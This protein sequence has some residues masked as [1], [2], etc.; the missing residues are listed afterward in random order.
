[1]ASGLGIDS[2][3]GWLMTKNPDLMAK[4]DILK[5]GVKLLI[6][7]SIVA[8]LIVIFVS[9]VFPNWFKI[10][11]KMQEFNYNTAKLSFIIFILGAI[12]HLPLNA[13]SNSLASFGKAY[14]GTLISTIQVFLNFL[15]LIITIKAKF[16][17]PMY[18]FLYSCNTVFCS[19]IK[20]IVVLHSIKKINHLSVEIT[21]NKKN[22]DNRYI[23]IL[24]MGIN[25]SL[26]GV[27]LMLV[28]N[29]SNLIISNNIA[30]DALVPYSLSYKLY[31]TIMVFVTNM[32]IAVSPMLGIEFG[33]KNWEWLQSSY[34]KMFEVTVSLSIFLVLGVIW[35]S[36]PFVYFWTGSV[37]NYAG[38]VISIFLGLYFFCGAMS[39]INHV[40]IN[41]F[42]YT[43]G[44][45]IVSWCDGV[46]FLISSFLL[47]KNLG[48]VGVP[49][50]LCIGAYCVSIW[51]YPYLIYKRTDKRFLYDFK[52]L[53]KNL[54][55]FFVSVV[56][57]LFISSLNLPFKLE[58]ILSFVGMSLT[59]ILI[60]LLLP[61]SFYHFLLTKYGKE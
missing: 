52:Y 6:L 21:I 17:L 31:S 48:V 18:V 2:A 43:K 28:P 44:V 11:G 20:L 50:G 55:I 25:M 23:S 56:L 49:L 1:M 35:F 40:I 27:A 46:L 22:D 3:T 7:C 54:I 12:L 10:L 19:F 24:K 16:S 59:S 30:V 45:W 42:D 9:L 53:A 29:I 34:K 32:N 37:E 47:T 4:V 57:F 41:A 13:V 5:K 61:K 26:Y 33:K 51:A 36:R 60:F 39:N 8:F 38:N 15:V 14:V 58:T